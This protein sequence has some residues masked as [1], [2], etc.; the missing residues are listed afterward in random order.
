M[1]FQANPFKV[2]TLDGRNFILAEDAFY[3]AAN[4]SVYKMPVG[5]TT[6]GASTPPILWENF[7]MEW[8]PPFGS[9]WRAA[10]LHD[11]AY[12][13][14]LQVECL[15]MGAEAW[16][17]AALTKEQCDNLLREAMESLGTHNLTIDEIYEGVVNG[18]QSSF[19]ADRS[20]GA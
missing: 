5:A 19:D 3:T 1:P 14:T 2:T 16:M 6:D 9:Y 17:K 20:K 11:C 10:V 18:G 7:G 13:N 12:R 4:G 15:A 8:L